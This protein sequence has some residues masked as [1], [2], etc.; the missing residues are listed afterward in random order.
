MTPTVLDSWNRITS[1]FGTNLPEVIGDLNPPATLADIEAVERSLGQTL[2]QD[3]KDLYL[4][5]N[6]QKEQ[7]FGLFFGVWF[8]SL[9]R[10]LEQWNT[11]K[12]LL[13]EDPQFGL[14]QARSST[15]IEM[16]RL[17]Y[18]NTAWIPFSLD[19]L[20]NHFGLDF[21]PD[22]AGVNG[23]VINFGRYANKKVVIASTFSEFLAWVANDLERGKGR[24][25][26]A[27]GM[28]LFDHADL[29]DVN[30]EDG[31]MTILAARQ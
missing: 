8:L 1:W 13:A 17:Q 31:L 10:M 30:L 25:Y 6:G 2:P 4:I 9:A 27:S 12:K 19:G 16:V 24:V 26:E 21:D 7:R 11:W 22:S 23:Q 5:A 3:L 18:I 28:K 14:D 20:T 29:G 15:P